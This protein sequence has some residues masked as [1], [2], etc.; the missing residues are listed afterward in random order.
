MDSFTDHL[1]FCFVLFTFSPVWCIIYL[2]TYIHVIHV[3]VS[4]FIY[5]GVSKNNGTPKWMVYNKTLLKFM[6]WGYQYF[7]KHPY[8]HILILF[9]VKKNRPVL[10]F[11]GASKGALTIAARDRHG[12]VGA[13]IGPFRPFFEH[14]KSTKTRWFLWGKGGENWGIVFFLWYWCQPK[15]NWWEIIGWTQTLNVWYVYLHLHP[16]LRNCR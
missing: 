2:Y 1:Q 4:L 12:S 14:E 6:I 13:S 10:L 7:W 3:I 8:I 9:C 15:K 5:M 16:N 11:P